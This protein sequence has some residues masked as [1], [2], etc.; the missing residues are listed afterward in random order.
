MPFPWSR[1]TA[2][3]PIAAAGVVLAALIG[4]QLDRS[5]ASA[6]EETEAIVRGE[7]I[8]KQQCMACHGTEGQ[9][10]DEY[11]PDPLVGDATIG[12]LAELIS[13]TMPEE[14]PDACVA[15][16][17]VAVATYIHHD[18]YSEA[19]QVRRRPPRAALARLT[20]DQLRQSLADVYSRVAGSPWTTTERGLEASYYNGR[21]W[22]EE[23]KKFTRIDS[24]INF[25][26]GH[27]GPGEGVEANAFHIH[28]AGSL[29]VDQTGRYEIIARSTCSFTIEFGARERELIDNHVQ[30]EGKEEFRRT[31]FL[32]GG[33][34]YPIKVD[35]NQRERK[36]EQPPASISLSWIPPGGVEEIIPTEQ[37]LPSFY[38]AVF[39]LQ[40]KLPPDDRSYGYERGNAVSRAWEEST[41][42][43]AIEFAKLAAEELYPEYRRKH[44]K[45]ADE[46]RAKL[47][48]FLKTLVEAA[49]R[50]PVDDRLADLY[51]DRQ[52]DQCPDD[53]EAIKQVMLITLKSPRFLYPTLDGDR[54]PSV[55]SANRLAL[56]LYDSLPSED[57][58]LKS[59]E[60]NQ[61]T[62]EKSIRQAAWRMVGDYRCQAKT[63]AFLYEW[64]HLAGIDEITKDKEAYPG[65]DAA[66]VA[67]LRKSFD[68][69]V[70]EV[71]Q[72][73][74]SD[75]RQ[76][77]QADW[78]YTTDRLA[79]FYGD[80]WKPTQP[81]QAMSRS[82][83]DSRVHVGVLTH[84]LLMSNLAYHRTTSPIHRGVF[85]TRHVLGRV[86][87][88]PNAAF[89][90]LNPDLH[91]GLTT[92]QRVELQTGEVSCQVCHSK[93]NA[94]GFALENFD[95]TGAYRE[96][97]HDQ[98][99]DASGSYITRDGE[100]KSFNGGR[101]LGD[102][103]AGN[104]DCHRAFVESAF[105]H[106]VKQPIAAFGADQSDRLTKQF[107][108]S[109]FNVRE[110]IVSIA[111]I[112]AQD[113]ANPVTGT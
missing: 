95:A 110:L 86:L 101:E 58:L 94:V 32:V 97:E 14:D 31:V 25:D 1:S 42:S 26:F 92:R 66:L 57:W 17:A 39:G 82:V 21:G 5:L 52:V 81:D 43:A 64:F 100:T 102:F 84:P 74:T 15:Q 68:R 112:V 89:S 4:V 37:L 2:L 48:A 105:E 47:K 103:L 35:M 72:S 75:F 56:V 85:L 30:S 60:K 91:P 108:D 19:A 41:T 77:L 3:H 33:R 78:S 44:K 98:P 99:I 104:Q 51:I 79:A 40:A 59:I 16:D 67:D 28:W 46:N 106:F 45:D 88:P 54:S 10:V 49:F 90:P 93:I 80:A 61:L 96:R 107:Q 9:G 24:A 36:T 111:T 23:D 18:F 27:E 71:V 13:D 53:V 34:C 22:K 12:E 7:Q 11:F 87:R 65:F 62:N 73:E 63:R 50:G 70:D 55:R 29:K 76:L 113:A 83:S 8:Y 38:P 69:F 20:A 6:A 109:G